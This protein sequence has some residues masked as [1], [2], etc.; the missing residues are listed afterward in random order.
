MRIAASIGLS[1]SIGLI[2]LLTACGS[3]STPAGTTQAKKVVVAV[4][5]EEK[6]LSYTD[7]KGNLAGY[8]VDAL[9]AIDNIIPEYDFDI[10]SVEADSQQIGLDSGKY[11][12]IAEGL[13]KHRKTGKYLLPE[14]M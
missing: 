13:F 8:E 6:P 4:A 1:V 7:D 14:E 9:K 2:G 5:T 10:Q 12:L 3:S 11:A